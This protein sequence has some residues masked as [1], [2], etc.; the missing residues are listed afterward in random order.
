MVPV[1]ITQMRDPARTG[2]VAQKPCATR[3]SHAGGRTRPKALDATKC[4]YNPVCKTHARHTCGVPGRHA[5]PGKIAFLGPAP[6]PYPTRPCTARQPKAK[7]SNTAPRTQA[8]CQ[9]TSSAYVHALPCRLHCILPLPAPSYTG[10]VT[11]TL[12]TDEHV[13]TYIKTKFCS[14]NG[15][16][17]FFA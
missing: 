3:T 5:S 15:T 7:V 14:N 4:H 11:C 1:S 12:I 2:S 9:T 6:L 8:P 13:N 10:I 16:A 17:S